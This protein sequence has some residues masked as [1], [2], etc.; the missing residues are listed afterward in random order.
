M[1]LPVWLDRLE[2]RD[3][4]TG[5][6]LGGKTRG[7]LR[8]RMPGSRHQYGRCQAEV[9]T[10]DKVSDAVTYA[11]VVKVSYHTDD[12]VVCGT[13]AEVAAE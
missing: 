12:D 10:S 4:V 3:A 6:R 9:H 7:I 13:N 8:I 11:P 2:R 5:R 1:T